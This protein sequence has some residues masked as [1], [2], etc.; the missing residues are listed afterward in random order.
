MSV[1]G[2]TG[3]HADPSS[4]ADLAAILARKPDQQTRPTIEPNAESGEPGAGF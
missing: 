1:R 4:G 3:K 2:N